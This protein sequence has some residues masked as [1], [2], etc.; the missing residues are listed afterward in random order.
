MERW[1]VPILG[2]LVAQESITKLL[3]CGSQRN[4]KVV[5]L[6]AAGIYLIVGTLPVTLGL[7]APLLLKDVPIPEEHEQLIITLSE[8]FLSPSLKVVFLG[9]LLAAILSTIDAIVVGSGGLISHNVI[10]PLLKLRS[11]KQKLLMARLTTTFMALSAYAITLIG[12]SIY[13][14]VIFASSWGSSGLVTITLFGLWTKMGRGSV[15]FWT[16][17]VG[18][19]SQVILDWLLK[20][21]IPFTTSLLISILFYWVASYLDQAKSYG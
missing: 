18:I 10:S 5:A 2:S 13:D 11:D 14:L 7:L 21:P 20:W 1:A 15:A 19:L 4:A 8:T 12:Q 17:L 3:A 9:S 6:V 16:L